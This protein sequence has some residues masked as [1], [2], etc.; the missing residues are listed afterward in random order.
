MHFSLPPSTSENFTQHALDCMMSE[1]LEN[2]RSGFCKAV[3][4]LPVFV[5]Q[6]PQRLHQLTTAL[7]A[8]TRQSSPRTLKWA[9]SRRLAVQAMTS[10]ASKTIAIMPEDLVQQIGDAMLDTL[11]DYTVDAR[12]DIGAM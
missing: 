4:A 9:E 10:V 1:N 8:C 11:N 2:V 5:L 6:D 3:G 7:I 12:G